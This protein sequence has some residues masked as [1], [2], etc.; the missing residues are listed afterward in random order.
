MFSLDSHSKQTRNESHLFH[1]LSFVYATDLTFPEHV[2]CF[3][4]LQ[5]SPRALRR[6]ETHP[7]LDQPFDE[8]M[9]LLDKVVEVF[10]L[11]QFATVRNK[12]LRFQLFERLWISCVFIHGDDARSA[13]MRRS[14]H[15]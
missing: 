11:T 14:R 12:S 3:I 13:G 10:A 2:H 6:K 9:I 15:L 7:E 5:G 1:A 8:A 4:A